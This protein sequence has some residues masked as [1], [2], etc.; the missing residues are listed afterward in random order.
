MD[1]VL[2]NLFTSTKS[3]RNDGKSID[4]EEKKEEEK[5]LSRKQRITKK[6]QE[7]GMIVEPE[8]FY[9]QNNKT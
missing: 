9:I 2:Y 8:P 6:L 1:T 4:F 7:K 5:E 3:V